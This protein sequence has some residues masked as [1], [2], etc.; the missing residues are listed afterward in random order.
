MI[1]L[2]LSGKWKMTNKLVLD[3]HVLIWS[4][5]A[6]QNLSIEVQKTIASAQNDN[7]LYIASISLWE[8]AMLV[9]KKRL[10]IYEPVHDF[11]RHI[12]TLDGLNL[13]NVNANIAAESSMLLGDFHGDPADR[14]IVASVRA[15]SGTLVTRDQKIIEWSQQGYL[16]LIVG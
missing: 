7:A 3:T 2:K 11:L 14:L 10:N 13:I 16:K 4:L 6:P 1:L 9:S 12:E 5:I 8:I 15:I